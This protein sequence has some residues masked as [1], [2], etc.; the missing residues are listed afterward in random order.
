MVLPRH[1]TIPLQKEPFRLPKLYR[2]Q[3]LVPPASLQHLRHLSSVHMGPAPP[4][5][6]NKWDFTEF[7]LLQ[8]PYFTC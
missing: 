6:T 2:H 4:G 8:L 1:H 3:T 7:V 5:T